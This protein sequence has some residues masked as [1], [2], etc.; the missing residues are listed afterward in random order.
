MLDLSKTRVH[1]SIERPVAVGAT[2]TAE[3]QVLVADV[4]SSVFGVKPSTGAA[5]EQFMGVS[6]AQQLTPL[7][8]PKVEVL[9]VAAA[10]TTSAPASKTIVSGTLRVVA[11]TSGELTAGNPATTTGQYSV[12]LNTGIITVHADQTGEDLT[13]YY[14]YSPTTVEAQ[15]LQGNIPPGGAA[16]LTLDSVGVIEQGDIF[17]TEYD[18]T[19]N[20]EAA[21]PV[22]VTMGANGVFTTGGNVTV[23]ARVIAVPTTT[24]PYLGLRIG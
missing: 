24:N 15:M 1:R 3:G 23:N 6:L 14:R 21:N 18:T 8:M 2:V 7:Y 4:S 9:V 11:E 10:A 16:S 20:W 13:V 19:I 5:G 22:A 17:T 12:D